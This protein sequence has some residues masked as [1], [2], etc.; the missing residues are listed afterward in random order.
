MRNE[1]KKAQAN[2]YLHKNITPYKIK[3]YQNEQYKNI[4][5]FYGYAGIRSATVEATV[6]KL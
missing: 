3:Y 6:E 1:Y 2:I 4:E 5:R